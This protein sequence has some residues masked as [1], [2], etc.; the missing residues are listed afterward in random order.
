MK[1]IKLFLVVSATV[2]SI[3]VYGQSP[4]GVTTDLGLWVKADEGFTPSLW[5]DKSGNNYHLTQN[6][7]TLQP[8]L[9]TTGAKFN[10]NP[11]V[12]FDSKVMGNN[13]VANQGGNNSI[14][15]Y[16]VASLETDSGANTLIGIG[17]AGDNPHFGAYPNATFMMYTS[18]YG[19]SANPAIDMSKSYLM[20]GHWQHNVAGTARIELN[21]FTAR[22]GG[23]QASP[24]GNFLVG[25]D[26]I[27]TPNQP[28][29]GLVPEVI[30]YTSPKSGNENQRV[31]SYLGI[32]YGLTL[33]TGGTNT[34]TFNYLSSASTT[35]WNGAGNAAYHNNVFGIARDN[36]SALHQKQSKSVNQDQK[37]I[38]GAGTSLFSMNST[39]TNNL[40][41]GQFLVV[42]DNGMKQSLAVSLP[43]TS[44]PGGKVNYR[45][46]AV[47]KVQNT[48][49]TGTVI[50]AWPKEISNLH[51]VRSSDALFDTS[52]EFIP[53]AG[54]V[55]IS[56][57][58]YNTATVTFTDGDYFTFAGYGRG[59][60]GV[61]ADLGLWVKAD[62]GFTPSLWSDK[63]GN[64][65]HLTQNSTTLQPTLLTTGAK[66]NFN[67]AV[68]FDSKVM[69]NNQ[70][71]NQGGNNSISLYSVASL[72]T[73]SGANTLIGIGNAGDNPHF[74]AYPNAT[75]MMYTSLYGSSAN[76]AIDMSKS[77]LMS[78][79][80][81][82]NVAGTARIE[83]NGFTARSGGNQA[84]P[85]GNFLVGND[86]INT[87]N[88][89]WRGLVPEV[90]A[91]TSPKSGNENQRVNSYLGIK[92]G[93][94]LR[95]GGTNTGTFNYLSSAS[96]TVWNG[97]GNAAYHNNVFGI[98]RDDDSTLLQKQSKSAN[99]DQKLI[100]GAGTSLFN[101]NSTNTNIL[102]DGQFLVVGDNGMKQ[103]L[104]VSL[105]YSSA[106]GGKVNYRFESFWKVQ[107]TENTGTVIVAWPKEILNLHLVRSSDTL[108]D[109]S[110]EF[111]PMV[112]TVTINGVEY[113]TATV[114]FN[115]KDYFTFA[116]YAH[117][118]GGVVRGLNY[119]Y[120]ADKDA[121]NTGGGTDVTSWK[122]FF[123]GKVS[124]QLGTNPL[125]KYSVGAV[126][127]FNFNPGI[128]FTA[129]TQTLGTLGV[130]TFFDDSYDVFTFT[131]E[132]MSSGGNHPSIFRSLVD[133][134]LL[135]G[136]IRRWDGL[137]IL[138]DNRIERLSN[139]GGNTDYYGIPA[140]AFSASIPSI[141]YHTFTTL[142][143]SK[144]LNG[145]SNFATTTHSG[146]G[147]KNL[148]GGHLF[149]NSQFS[150]NGSD[151]QG[152]I[153]NLGETI[154]YGS[155]NLTETERRRVDSYMAIKY[156]I[157]LGRVATNHYLSS[158]EA[159]VWD[160]TANATFNNNIFGIGRDD[161][162]ALHQKVSNS[163]N[164]GTILT[165][166][167]DNDFALENIA[168]SRTTISDD[169]EFLIAGDNNVVSIPMQTINFG[170][171][172]AKIIQRKWLFQ[173]TGTTE[174][175]FIQ[176]NL[177]AYESQFYNPSSVYM[178]IADDAGFTANR[179]LVQG[180]KITGK[181]VFNH[182]F[183][184]ENE[185]RYITF[186]TVENTICYKPGAIVTSENPALI[187]KIGISSLTRV[188]SQ[189]ADNWPAVRK[190]AWLVLEARTK[191]FVVNR[192]SFNASGNPVGIP[193]ADF[194]EGMLVYDT[195]NKCLKM[196][197]SQDGGTTFAW[198][199]INTQTC[200][201]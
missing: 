133:N 201:D 107:N 184:T 9:L 169:Q 170:N 43:Y 10:F 180:T 165:M 131:K 141:M 159:M 143:T 12:N 153:G 69:G 116:G 171:G 183:D 7:T 57:V 62:E 104:A 72:E 114:T 194:V 58:E 1:K 50:V 105:P 193:E 155:G 158:T 181:W 4:G 167:T 20:S 35:V 30:A 152:F 64:N 11:A 15:L 75:F 32:K 53:M 29:R 38:I 126:N 134:S 101:M 173:R 161:I 85:A 55:T 199:C 54:T 60:G 191:G 97:A 119:W 34:G 37:L 120:R 185:K 142:T 144:A 39:N 182:D 17:N 40:T 112:G 154:I 51:L 82:H 21:G 198:S 86:F 68:N 76:P 106:P 145:A 108:F 174:N 200:P 124:I 84:S 168:A 77:Y 87:P 74:G 65:Y 176:A 13:Q 132:G 89:P 146:T 149:G 195:T 162:S 160:G 26:F 125:P 177:S 192:L 96:T 121:V 36:A 175:I 33:R 147:V 73:D 92:Y 3:S 5:S 41:D 31:N 27:N 66:F 44:A 103:S 166:A 2:C 163:V 88:Q 189:N 190:G 172:S 178:V 90:I 70:V 16:S 150:G 136:G 47:W 91:Y 122:D 137:G 46:S 118:P 138:M 24:A 187:S 22:S 179:I 157:T 61:T 79:H 67:P 56:G 71:A 186:A 14:S 117:A 80:W 19:S 123:S 188:G 164:N 25:N 81:Q 52:D 151:N 111:I 128:N 48:G 94:T 139:V 95:T 98:A 109:T 135:T 140:G 83:L 196:Y 28:W 78:G 93:L 42:G 18:L 59:P 8:T 63:S 130:R 102:T 197:T 127:Y 148:N 113:N 6:S 110:D 156:G 115:D 49:N 129:G 100:I 99:S 23:N 45:F